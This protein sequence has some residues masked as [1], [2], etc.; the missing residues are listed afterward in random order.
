MMKL[1]NIQRLRYLERFGKTQ[2]MHIATFWVLLN[3]D[4]V[5]VF[6]MEYELYERH[7]YRSFPAIPRCYLVEFVTMQ[8]MTY[9]AISL[10]FP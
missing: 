4:N 7:L 10:S 9:V 3:I 8:N 2:Y 6:E 1:P 5:N